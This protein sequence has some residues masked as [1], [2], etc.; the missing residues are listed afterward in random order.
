MPGTKPCVRFQW[1]ASGNEQEPIPSTEKSSWFFQIGTEEKMAQRFSIEVRQ[2]C[3]VSQESQ[4][5]CSRS[6][7]V[8]LLRRLGL[9]GWIGVRSPREQ[10]AAEG[11]DADDGDHRTPG[12]EK[13]P[14]GIG[15]K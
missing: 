14:S 10:I 1:T 3:N 6:G 2:P 12:G 13:E 4:L 7:G 11:D 9:R 15:E 5:E 8:N